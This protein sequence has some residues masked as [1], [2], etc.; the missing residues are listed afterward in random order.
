MT[1]RARHLITG[2]LV[3]ES[4]LH[5]GASRSDAVTD[6]PV[7]RDGS[8]RPLLPGTSLAGVLRRTLPDDEA[9]RWFGSHDGSTTHPS[10]VIVDDAP[11]T[12]GTYERHGTQI[13]TTT[14]IDPRTGAVKERLL[15]SREV[16]PQGTIFSLSLE[17]ETDDEASAEE[18]LQRLAGTLATGIRVGAAI[19]RGLGRVSLDGDL[20][21]RTIALQERERF[22]DFLSDVDHR[23]PVTPA[24]AV[25][26]PRSLMFALPFVPVGPL[27][28]SVELPGGAVDRVPLTAPT[29]AG[30]VRLTLPGSSI[31]GALRARALY[32]LG[33]LG[34]S[35][36]D[37]AFVTLF[38]A[39]AELDEERRQLGRRG[40]LIVED[41]GVD[42][43]I[44]AEKWQAVLDAS[45]QEAPRARK[46]LTT[47]LSD[48]A[49]DS[50]PRFIP[51]DRVAVDR[52][53]GGA[54]EPLLYSLLEP[55][56]HTE[57][58]E[59]LRLTLDL[60][61]VPDD[62]ARRAVGLLLMVL[63]EVR[64]GWVKFGYGT[65]RGLGQ[66][67]LAEG[68]DDISVGES[69]A[70]WF[71][72]RDWRITGKE[73]P[74]QAVDDALEAF[75]QSPSDATSLLSTQEDS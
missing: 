66:V 55:H 58:W 31:K 41:S 8:G 67:R 15:F 14:A 4:A 5:V 18:F 27:M 43:P 63:R 56:H 36:D 53:T 25:T 48:L 64:D 39:A 70:G 7:L 44:P 71:P 40:R 59:P 75:I 20:E 60:D 21:R 28:T 50:L 3:A 19:T 73:Q 74:P 42:T 47:A 57:E 61:G 24:S 30:H 23:S 54:A 68:K 38:G 12:G 51:A 9:D 72:L 6:L 46:A 17:L 34:K 62:E 32:L 16:V 45:G 37:P 1:H 11:A 26:E 10:V 22:L 29:E 13:R 33:T 52:W 35:A 65:R 2:Q 69:L 49:S